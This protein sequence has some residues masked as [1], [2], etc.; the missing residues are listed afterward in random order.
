[1]N[2]NSTQYFDYFNVPVALL[3]YALKF[4][5]TNQVKLFLYL[6]SISSGYVQIQKS[7]F[8]LIAEHLDICSKTLNSYLQW[9]IQEE[10][11]IVDPVAHNFRLIGFRRLSE[12][13]GFTISTGALL[14]KNDIPKFKSFAVAAVITYLIER[15]RVRKWQTEAG[16]I[17]GNPNLSGLPSYPFL[18]HSYL[19]KTLELSKTTAY[20]FRKLT[21][22]NEFLKCRKSYE[23]QNF[24]SENL[25]MLKKYYPENPDTLRKK[26]K[27]IYRQLPDMIESSVYLRTKSN[28]WEVC[29]KNRIG[30]NPDLFKRNLCHEVKSFHDNNK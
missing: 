5:K 27:Q 24:T 30:K 1:M 9:L 18:P 14:Y 6:K 8:L 26:G 22:E 20:D 15:I 10:W 2:K 12:K 4:K 28:I 11:L 19:A 3:I 21:V 25:K 16:L 7:E 29:Q 23:D 13:L 17:K